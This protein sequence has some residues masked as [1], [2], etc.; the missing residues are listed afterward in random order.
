MGYYYIILIIFKDFLIYRGIEILL[1]NTYI[2]LIK[3]LVCCGVNNSPCSWINMY[4]TAGI[5]NMD[6]ELRVGYIYIERGRES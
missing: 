6:H 2:I 5:P 1:Y 4:R 3:V